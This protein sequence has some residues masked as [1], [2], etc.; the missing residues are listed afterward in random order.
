MVSISLPAALRRCATL[1][2]EAGAIIMDIYK[3]SFS[4]YTKPDATPITEADKRANDLIVTSLTTE[5]PAVSILAEETTDDRSRLENDWC[6]IIDPLDGTKGFVARNG[7]FTVNIGLAYQH[8]VVLGV[9]YLPVTGEI[10][11]AARGIGASYEKDG[12]QTPIHVSDRLDKLRMVR[13]KNHPDPREDLLMAEHDI[14]DVVHS[15]SSIKGCLVARGEADVYYR[16]GETSE[17]DTAAMQCIVEQAGGIFRQTDGSPMLY[18]R[19]DTRNRLG[20]AAVNRVEN[21]WA[22]PTNK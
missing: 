8:R 19:E 1:A 17:W 3:T 21:M 7:E 12:I 11:Y 4:V 6:F 15:G 20:F 14:T 18:N 16:Y 9:I 2:R 22:L 10:Y 5:Y 13:S